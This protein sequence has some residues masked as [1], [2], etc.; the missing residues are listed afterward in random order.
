[1][2]VQSVLGSEVR[3]R[4]GQRFGVDAQA[5]GGVTATLRASHKNAANVA[6]SSVIAY[7]VPVSPNFT[8]S[9]WSASP[10]ASS[11]SLSRMPRVT[12]NEATPKK[13]ATPEALKL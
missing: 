5:R 2:W 10:V 4:R 6:L 8:I 7:L 1:M 3:R 12:Q 13:R 11:S 9:R